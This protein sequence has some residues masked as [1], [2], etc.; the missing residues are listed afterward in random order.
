MVLALANWYSENKRDLPWRQTRDAYSVWISEVML[1]QTTVTAVIPYYERFLR[2]FPTVASLASAREAEVLEM[3]AGLGYYS[4]A[5]MLYRSA[6]EIAKSH[7]PK[8]HQELLKLHGFG[9]YTARAVASL[10]HGEAVG[11]VDG[12]V[13]RVLSRLFGVQ[14]EWWK[15]KGR[16]ELQKLA[17]QLVLEGHSKKIKSADINQAFMDLGSMICTPKNPKCFLCPWV[18]VCVAFKTGQPENYSLAKPRR[19]REIWVWRP[20]IQKK[21]QKVLL[22]K[23]QYA[24]FLKGQW[25][26]PGQATKMAKAPKKFLFRHSITHH[27]IFVLPEPVLQVAAQKSNRAPGGR[28]VD[29]KKVVK[30]NPTSL[31]KKLLERT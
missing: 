26:P 14:N 6:Q 1:Q 5:R 8:T 29:L 10:A 30:L 27:D 31:I 21:G 15:P 2:R 25:L 9:P 12:N 20:Q 4:R 24:P 3:W 28:F 7:F 11:V 17:D 22:V 18:K 23:N 16:E 19:A 13:V